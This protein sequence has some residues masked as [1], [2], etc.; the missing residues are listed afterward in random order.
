MRVAIVGGT[1]FIG[2]YLVDA[3]LSAGHQPALLVRPGSESKVHKADLCQLTPGSI[4][5]ADCLTLLVRGCDAVIF[6]IGILRE[7]PRQG[8]TFEKLQYQGL[9]ATADAAREAGVSRLLLMSAN[10]AKLPG[11]PYQETKKRAED[12]ALRCGLDVTVIQPS[13]VFGDPRGL[14]EIASQ[15]YNDMIRPPLP[16]VAFHNGWRPASGYVEMS[17]VH[18]EDVALAF[19]NALDDESTFGAV[20]ELG[21]P[22]VLNWREMLERIAGAVGKNKWILPVP[23]KLMYVAASVLDRFAFFPVTRDQLTML[24]AGNVAGDR[25]LRKLIGRPPTAMVSANLQ[26]LRTD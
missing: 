22:E 19:V 25:Q 6:N 26:Y 23:V 5:E 2:S 11:T 16:A 20:I 9:V 4:D 10:G 21:G 17:P 18:V 24:A 12:Y 1:G 3:L 13:V 7:N 14:N 15:L 8:V